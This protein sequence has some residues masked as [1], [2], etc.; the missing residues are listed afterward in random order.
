ML[1]GAAAGVAA[2]EPSCVIERLHA[3][4]G[5]ALFMGPDSPL[6]RAIGMGRNGSV[7]AEEIDEV[8]NFFRSRGAPVRIALSERAHP[9]LMRILCERGYIRSA[10]MQ[11]WYLRLQERL[12]S[13]DSD[14][15]VEPAESAQAD[16]WAHTVGIGFQEADKPET[17]LDAHL[18]AL[19]KTLG[20]A[21]D[22]RPYFALR[23]GKIAGGA[24]LSVCGNV[25]FLRT[26]SSRWAHRSR[27]VQSALI[28]ARLR[29]AEN[30]G[31]SVV[32][33]STQGARISER[34][35]IRNGFRRLSQSYVME[36]PII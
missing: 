10:P 5:V 14:I 16:L 12:P 3:A 36:K 30:L 2:R 15:T 32:F 4:G 13:L 18:A 6:N 26:A 11:N 20:F 35:L 23:N 7:A 33:S 22:S 24:V 34:N 31:C 25:G 19:F 8:E 9:T 1:E 17:T 28:S 21:S 27:G 29:D